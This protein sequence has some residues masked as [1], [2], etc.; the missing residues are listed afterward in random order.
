MHTALFDI[1]GPWIWA[2]F[3][4]AALCTEEKGWGLG[5]VGNLD[6]LSGPSGRGCE[7]SLR[8]LSVKHNVGKH[9]GMTRELTK[10]ENKV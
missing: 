8:T 3:S 10:S 9:G 7:W 5:L 6:L 4:H 1:G 2:K